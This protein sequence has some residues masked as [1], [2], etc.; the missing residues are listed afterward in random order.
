MSILN[1]ERY[2][3]FRPI[4]F[5][6]KLQQFRSLTV[7]ANTLKSKLELSPSHEHVAMELTMWSS[8]VNKRVYELEIVLAKVYLQFCIYYFII[9][10]QHL[11]IT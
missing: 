6:F 7:I 1:T 11:N 8:W 3:Y 9:V 10:N 4:Y 5:T 2:P